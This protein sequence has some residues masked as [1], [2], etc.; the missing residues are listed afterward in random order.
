[1]VVIR[2][3]QIFSYFS[4]LSSSDLITNNVL[5]Y[6]K[7]TTKQSKTNTTCLPVTQVSSAVTKNE[8]NS[9]S[10]TVVSG[11]KKVNKLELIVNSQ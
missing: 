10:K 9:K 8:E 5:R 4:Q 3:E 7:P 6:Y 11:K 1:M 2:T